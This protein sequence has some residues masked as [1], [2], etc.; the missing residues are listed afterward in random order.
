M[1]FREQGWHARF[2]QMGDEAEGHFVTWARRQAM[3]VERLGWDRPKMGVGRMSPLL[4]QMPDFYASDGFLYEVVGMG[5]DDIL[6]GVKVARW[7]AR[8]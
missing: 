6:K 5:R 3:T 8:A 7:V 2:Q 1:S 4:R